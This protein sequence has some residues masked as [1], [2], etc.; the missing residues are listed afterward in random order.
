MEALAALS[1]YPGCY[2]EWRLIKERYQL[3]WLD[4]DSLDLFKSII[5]AKS[6]YSSM[7]SWLKEIC[8]KI[9][10]DYANILLYDVLIGLR[11]TEACQS[12]SLIQSDNF[13]RYLN[14]DTM[15]LEHYKY[16]NIFIRNSKKA[17]ISIVNEDIIS[18]AKNANNCGY[19]TL[20]NYL[21]RRK[22]EMHMGY[23]V[24]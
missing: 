7:V 19:N 10:K 18:L 22:L 24:R 5:D 1:K 13:D 12:I 17:F 14:T 23:C 11:P 15:I 8:Q 9:P 21:K 2:D 4:K 16:P 6:E 20:R 3:K